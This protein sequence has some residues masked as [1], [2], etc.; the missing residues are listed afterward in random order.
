MVDM[1]GKVGCQTGRPL[2]IWQEIFAWRLLGAVFFINL[3]SRPHRNMVQLKS[4]LLVAF[5]IGLT[6][7]M[8]LPK[9]VDGK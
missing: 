3:F 5:A 6:M 9:P 7:A 2:R 4:P 1:V 8:A